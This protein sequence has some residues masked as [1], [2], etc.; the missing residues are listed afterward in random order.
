MESKYFYSLLLKAVTFLYNYR[1]ENSRL[2]Y[3]IEEM[4]ASFVNNI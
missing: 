3:P 2:N 1:G 4:F